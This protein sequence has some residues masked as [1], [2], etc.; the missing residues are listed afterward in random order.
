[1]TDDDEGNFYASC[2]LSKGE[3]NVAGPNRVDHHL[4]PHTGTT[5]FH[6]G[7]TARHFI[8]VYVPIPPDL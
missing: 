2:H 6:K 8:L 4:N 3:S 5:M 1:M 7:L